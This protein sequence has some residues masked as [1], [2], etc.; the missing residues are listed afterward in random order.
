M[1]LVELMVAVM[2]LAVGLLSLAAL[3]VVLNAQARGA[4]RQQTAA[5][6]VQSRIDSLASIHCQNLAPSGTQSGVAIT[7]G[8]TERWSVADG[9]DIKVIRDTVTFA[10]RKNPIAYVSLIPCRD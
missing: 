2:L 6:L 3:S 8:I 5:M 10:G 7:R 4:Q 9:N 1:T